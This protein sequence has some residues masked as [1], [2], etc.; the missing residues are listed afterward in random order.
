MWFVYGMKY[1]GASPGAQPKRFDVI[2]E[3]YYKILS[4]KGFFPAKKYHDVL[5]YA[6]ELCKEELDDYELE[7]LG[8]M[9]D[10]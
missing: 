8:V 10:E 6:R 1:R 9:D 3:Q 2:T 5:R 4:D 7:F